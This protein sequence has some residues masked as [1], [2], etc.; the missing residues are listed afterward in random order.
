MC[1]AASKAPLSS[2][3]LKHA[4]VTLA[5]LKALRAC[6]NL[7]DTFDAT[8]FA[9]ATIAFWCQCRLGEVCVDICFN[10][11]IHPAQCTPQ[12]TGCMAS[13]I[14][15]HSFWAPSIKTK[16]HGEFIMWTSSDCNCSTEWALNNHCS[17]N[18]FIPQSAHL[19]TFKTDSGSFAPM[20]RAWFLSW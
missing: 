14:I 20:K 1:G 9:V 19:F 5:H 16:P 8:V 15:F 6:L 12:K 11:L 3:H 10:P 4:P 7:N 18:C 2:S 13:N 17:I